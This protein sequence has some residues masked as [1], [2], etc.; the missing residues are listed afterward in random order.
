MAHCTARTMA[1]GGRCMSL[2]ALTM[3]A[4]L[5]RCPA[6]SAKRCWPAATPCGSRVRMEGTLTLAVFLC[7]GAFV[8]ATVRPAGLVRLIAVCA[9]WLALPVVGVSCG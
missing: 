1:R 6:D 7:A 9:G 5:A 4:A 2:P 8:L 3:A